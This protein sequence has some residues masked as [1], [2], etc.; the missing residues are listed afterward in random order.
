MA[1]HRNVMITVALVALVGFFAGCGSE[2]TTAPL[3]TAEAPV[4]AP[5]GISVSWMPDGNVEVTWAASTQAH[6][7]GYNLYRVNRRDGSI[8]QLNDNLISGTH[9]IDSGVERRTMYE[10]RVTAVS[11][12]GT[13]SNFSGTTLDP[14]GDEFPGERNGVRPIAP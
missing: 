2:S 12:L 5:V 13:E 1:R 10:Y 4:L 3:E 6:V 7:V 14:R 8:D 11:G 9:Y